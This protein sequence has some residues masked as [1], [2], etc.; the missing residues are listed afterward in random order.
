[1]WP[2]YRLF[3]LGT[4]SAMIESFPFKS[5]G[6]Y[7]EKDDFH[8]FENSFVQILN[9]RLIFSGK[10][11]FLGKTEQ[12]PKISTDYAVG[13]KLSSIY[14]KVFDENGEPA[15][16][17]DSFLLSFPLKDQS[18]LVAIITGVDPVVIERAA[19]DWLVELQE[20]LLREFILVKQAYKDAE[21]GL[22]NSAHFF[23]VVQS[24]KVEEDVT[25]ILVHIPVHSKRSEDAFRNAQ[26]AAAILTAATDSRFMIH[27]LG[28]C[29]FALL[30]RGSDIR[31]ID[32]FS[33]GLVH[34]FKEEKFS[35]IH[36]G[37]SSSNQISD[38]QAESK[39]IGQ[40]VLDQAWTALRTA[41][42]RGPFS[43]CD[44]SLLAN[45]DKH[46]LKPASQSVISKFSKIN[47]GDDLFSL[48]KIGN[49]QNDIEFDHIRDNEFLPKM[50]VVF[51]D[52]DALYVYLP[53]TDSEAAAQIARSL[54]AGFQKDQGRHDA[55]AGVSTFPTVSFSK[56]DM[57]ANAQ[58][59]LLHAD[60]FGPGHCVVF[61]SVSMNISGDIYF[62][63]GDLP[64]AVKEYRTGL[65][66]NPDDVNLLNSLGV[67]YALLNQKQQAKKTFDKAVAL[68]PSN[69]MA[70][71]NLGL[72]AQLRDDRIEA[73]TCF[74]KALLYCEEGNG[75]GGIYHDLQLQLGILY[76]RISNYS[77][78]LKY[79]NNW[80]PQKSE[81]QQGRACR[82]F[83]E[84]YLGVNQPRK[85]MV[86]L[87]RALQRNEYDHEV[88]SLLG[89]AIFEAQEGPDIALSL[90]NKSV[91][92]VPDDPS[93]R[94]RLAKVQIELGLFT[95]ALSHL[96]RC[97]GKE[98][99]PEQVH[100]LKAKAYAGKRMIAKARHWIIK[101]MSDS[102][103]GSDIFYEAEE[104]MKII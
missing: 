29:V 57:L 91:D 2:D 42:R 86:W 104:L 22:L 79:L 14:K 50:A 44:F 43:F 51:G 92:L 56:K 78:S 34:I 40:R 9:S 95:E 6:D 35:K 96:K 87:E 39:N 64:K 23:S 53:Q 101:C 88:L 82:Y 99:I 71:Y 52:C 1:M 83:G 4:C 16:V 26:R 74:E 10:V 102:E 33:S 36:I 45:K 100:L 89:L 66:L 72:G 38:E 3:F 5:V 103:V 41:R 37:I 60:F 62:S 80:L 90:C 31:N 7:L 32:Q 27:H 8:L 61:D 47:K 15:I 97:R 20:E 11:Y 18:I 94:L 65:K 75:G 67:T 54:L 73:I 19:S 85:A 76:C 28:Q 69:Y 46:P 55:Y 93:L 63:D 49:I 81:R 21:T 59:A 17:S 48:L 12:L 68:D 30:V 98:I 24:H 84:S 13:Q 25:T 58:K 77:Q 70:M